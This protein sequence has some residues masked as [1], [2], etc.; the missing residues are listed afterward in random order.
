MQDSK[1]MIGLVARVQISFLV[2][3]AQQV[4]LV[5]HTR[6]AKLMHAVV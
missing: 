2:K 5:V 3:V 6:V 1:R 4:L